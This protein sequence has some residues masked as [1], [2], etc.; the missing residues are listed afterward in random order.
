MSGDESRN[1]ALEQKVAGI[2]ERLKKLEKLL[3]DND[4]DLFEEWFKHFLDDKCYGGW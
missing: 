2:D 3:D 4:H 1:A